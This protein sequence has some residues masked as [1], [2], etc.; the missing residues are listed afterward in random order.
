MYQIQLRLHAKVE[1]RVDTISPEYHG[2]LFRMRSL[3]IQECLCSDSNTTVNI[4][5]CS[6]IVAS[7]DNVGAE[8]SPAFITDASST[9][10]EFVDNALYSL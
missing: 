10:V 5:S 1:S 6:W 8:A 2:C 9:A 3:S 7:S 4:F